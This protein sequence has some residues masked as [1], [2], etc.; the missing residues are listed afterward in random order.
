MTHKELMIES[1]LLQGNINRMMVT[2][3]KAELVRMFWFAM[4]RLDKIY[5]ERL[6]ELSKG[7]VKADE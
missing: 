7:K 2:K 6:F 5:V 3:D 1:D 4:K